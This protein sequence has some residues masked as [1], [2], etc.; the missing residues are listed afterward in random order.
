[1]KKVANRK[2]IRTLSYRTMREKKWKN[3]IAILAIALTSVLFTALFTVGGSMLTSFQESTFRQI[4]TSAHG[5]YKYLSMQ[6]FEQIKAAGGFRDISCDI[7]AG[8]ACNPELNAIQTEV[9]WAQDQA[10]K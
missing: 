10:A 3:L 5:G 7:V 9:R 1:M 8:F 4:G 6:E 2:V